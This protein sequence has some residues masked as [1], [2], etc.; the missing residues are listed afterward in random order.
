MQGTLAAAASIQASLKNRPS[1]EAGCLGKAGGRRG[2]VISPSNFAGTGSPKQPL[3]NGLCFQRC[4]EELR[5]ACQGGRGA[6]KGATSRTWERTSNPERARAS[7]GQCP[8]VHQGM[9]GSQA[10]FCKLHSREAWKSR[11]IYLPG[12]EG[13]TFASQKLSQL[14]CSQGLL[15]PLW[16]PSPAPWLDRSR[17]K[18]EKPPEGRAHCATEGGRDFGGAWARTP[19]SHT[20]S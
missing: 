12:G 20:T 4:G 3:S 17:G 10:D 18:E 2:P 19:S 13:N 6:C 11:K 1:P 15:P 14:L 7:L 16:R 5:Q 9:A 8:S